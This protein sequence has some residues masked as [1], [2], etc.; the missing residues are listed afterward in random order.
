MNQNQVLK[1]VYDLEERT[2]LFAK[3]IRLFVKT[4][5]NTVANHEDGKQLIR[6]SGSIGANYREANE[7]LGK[8]T[9]YCE[10]RLAEKKRK[11]VSI[12]LD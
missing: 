3:N 11:R 12:G 2:F 7:S 1:P 4:L 6:S 10:L 5:P 8:R 9:F